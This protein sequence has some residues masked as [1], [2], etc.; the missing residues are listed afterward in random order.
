MGLP[1]AVGRGE[2]GFVS[3]RSALRAGAVGEAGREVVH[4]GLQLRS[5]GLECAVGVVDGQGEAADLGMADGVFAAGVAGE[6]GAGG[7][8][9]GWVGGGYWGGLGGGVF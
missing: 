4:D 5:V 3:G 2:E 9:A 1:S 6:A 8:R 7:G